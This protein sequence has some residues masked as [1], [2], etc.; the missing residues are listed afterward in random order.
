MQGGS[1]RGAAAAVRAIARALRV[2]VGA[3]NGTIGR[4]EGSTPDLDRGAHARFPFVVRSTTRGSRRFYVRFVFRKPACLVRTQ[5]HGATVA[6]GVWGYFSLL[7]GH[8]T[9][10]KLLFQPVR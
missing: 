5:N 1:A 4:Q 10:R 7:R 2:V 3:E 8:G 9:R 6:H